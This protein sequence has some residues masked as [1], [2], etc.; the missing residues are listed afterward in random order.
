MYQATPTPAGRLSLDALFTAAQKA[1]P[2]W[3]IFD[4]EVL[5]NPNYTDRLRAF[6]P[7]ESK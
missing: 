6:P 3:T 4:W 2:G 7:G 5:P 1:L